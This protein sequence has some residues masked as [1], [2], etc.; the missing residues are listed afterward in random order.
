MPPPREMPPPEMPFRATGAPP[1][2]PRPNGLLP[3]GQAPNGAG[4]TDSIFESPR[5][6][7]RPRGPTPGPRP[8]LPAA[9]GARPR[10]QPGPRPP[11]AG[12]A[13][14]PGPAPARPAPKDR[15]G[16]DTGVWDPFLEDEDDADEATAG[17]ATSDRP[18]RPGMAPADDRDDRAE[19]DEDDLADVDPANDELDEE[20]DSL[21]AQAWAGVVAQWLAGAVVGAA[22]W[23]LFRYLWGELRIV[24]VAAALLVTAGLVMAVRHLLHD[25]SRRTTLLAVLVG[26][27]LTTS[28]V[29]LVLLGR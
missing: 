28:P 20:D 25:R 24:A 10:P 29:V 21:P 6:L 1:M 26:L 13:V 23:V 22:L 19:D 3:T 16:P 7:A 12:P 2:A 17:I 15:G 4:F 27:L 11:V 18:A 5:A 9:P 14:L 8:P